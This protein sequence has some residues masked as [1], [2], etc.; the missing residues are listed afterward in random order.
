MEASP[1]QKRAIAYT[2][3][4]TD[5]QADG[6][7]LAHQITEI[8][9]YC[10]D[11]EL[12][13]V[14]SFS[15]IESAATIKKR[16]AFK[17]AVQTLN[18]D[19]A[20]FIVCINFDR[21]SRNLLDFELIRRSLEQKGKAILSTQQSFL[22]P[23]KKNKDFDYRLAAQMQREMIEAEMER[24][25]IRERCLNGRNKKVAQGGWWGHRPPHEFDVVQG[26]LVL[27]L[28]RLKKIQAIYRHILR[29][30]KL[31]FTYRAVAAYLSG[32]NGLLNADGTRGR[33]FPV[34]SKRQTLRRRRESMKCGGG[35][36]WLPSTIFRFLTTYEQRRE[37][38][39][40]AERSE[41][42]A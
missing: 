41:R 15:E 14:G 13:L 23:I 4:S 27:N 9:Q 16:P 19:E 8:E 40:K 24:W 29:L 26:E 11:N 12:L 1:N 42:I 25:K 28:Q 22:T 34:L 32:D 2:R 39:S 37:L 5:G 3:V 20:D 38:W 17:Q 36:K 35:D 7:S 31:G 6:H 21:F 33:A 30:R 18:R 10:R